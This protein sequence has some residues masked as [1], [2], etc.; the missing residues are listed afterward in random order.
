MIIG[1]IKE[2][3][4]I[5]LLKHQD[6]FKIAFDFLEHSDT[7]ELREGKNEFSDKGVFAI[8][9]EY[10]THSIQDGLM[11]EHKKYL[12]IQYI[13]DGTEKM[14]YT[15]MDNIKV[16]KPYCESEDVLLGVAENYNEVVMNKGT[17]AILFPEEAH[18]PGVTH[19]K[20]CDVKKIVLKIPVEHLI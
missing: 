6:L 3:S 17:F 7:Y 9:L 18:M 12:D 5:D 16:T 11:E 2:K 19:I 14:L 8:Y 13:L 20:A 1:N 4:Q 10:S 15:N